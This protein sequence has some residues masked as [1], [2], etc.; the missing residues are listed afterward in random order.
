MKLSDSFSARAAG[1]DHSH[2]AVSPSNQ[3]QW[4]DLYDTAVRANSAWSNRPAV[5]CDDGNNCTKQDTC[6]LGKLVSLTL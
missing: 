2:Q 3:C 4:C 1:Q 5:S 6:N